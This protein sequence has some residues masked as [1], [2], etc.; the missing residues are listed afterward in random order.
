MAWRKLAVLSAAGSCVQALPKL[1]IVPAQSR[2]VLL[3]AKRSLE[4]VYGFD[5]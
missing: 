2:E 3:G 1:F 4:A 5:G